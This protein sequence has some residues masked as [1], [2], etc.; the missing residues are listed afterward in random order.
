M[1]YPFLLS[2]LLV[3]ACPSPNTPPPVPQPVTIAFE[4]PRGGVIPEDFVLPYPN[5]LW[6]QP[7]GTLDLSS[8]PGANQL[9]GADL[10]AEADGAFG[11]NSGIFLRF[12]G[13]ITESTIPD[14]ATTLTPGS[15]LFVVEVL[16]NGTL[17][18]RIPVQVRVTNKSSSLIPDQTIAIVPVFGL[19]FRRGARYVAVI[20]NQVLGG[21][22]TP[23]SPDADFL[24]IRAEGVSA[25]PELAAAEALYEPVLTAL[26]NAGTARESIAWATIFE[27]GDLITPSLRVGDFVFEGG[28]GV[29][30]PALSTAFTEALTRNG[31]ILYRGQYQTPR[32]QRGAPPFSQAPNGVIEFDANGDPIVQ[33]LDPVNVSVTIPDQDPPVGGWPVVISN[34][35]TGGDAESFFEGGAPDG[36]AVLLAQQGFAVIG[37]DQPL[38]GARFVPGSDVNLATFNPVNLG[39]TRENIRQAL[40]DNVQLIR[41]LQSGVVLDRGGQ[42]VPLD[43]STFYFMGHSQGSLSGP[44]LLAW[45]DPLNL[46]RAAVFSGPSGSI[47]LAV[48]DRII[49]L[50]NGTDTP[51]RDLFASVVGESSDDMD[52]FHPLLNLVQQIIE[53]N[54]PLNYGALLVKEAQNPVDILLTQGF[55]DVDTPPRTIDAMSSAIGLAPAIRIDGRARDILGLELQ[56]FTPLLPPFSANVG[57][58]AALAQFPDDDHFAIFRNADAQA[59]Y[60]HF[61]GTAL[62]AGRAEVPAYGAQ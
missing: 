7:D 40:A 10:L 50:P 6:K 43:G 4:V 12:R 53:P 51:A 41:I 58:T 13:E 36:E 62:S 54:D 56:G 11:S 45:A 30:A 55:E 18:E 39:A 48:T 22:Q 28:A 14:V 52:E 29:P 5:D 21:D 3:T 16:D 26:A 27:T 15:S 37:I 38:H 49:P 60:S 9:L 20:T 23:A 32:F 1:R 44:I 42:Q 31:V 34:H 25:D 35:G 17:G 2:A 59:V 24:A 61:L 33:A 46:F 57:V 8:F 19:G 47:A